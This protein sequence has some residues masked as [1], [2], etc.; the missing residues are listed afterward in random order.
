MEEIKQALEYIRDAEQ[1]YN[2]ADELLKKHGVSVCRP[3]ED[4]Y[5][6]KNCVQVY[7]GLALMAESVGKPLEHPLFHKRMDRNEVSFIHDGVIY[8]QL[9]TG[10]DKSDDDISD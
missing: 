7:K 5:P 4:A 10:S 2:K 9:I 6:V 8:F 1:L 3:L